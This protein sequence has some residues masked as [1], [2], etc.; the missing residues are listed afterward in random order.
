M[1]SRIHTPL[2]STY[3]KYQTTM[4]D[5]DKCEG[6]DENLPVTH[7]SEYV[8]SQC[9]PR[10]H[11][12][13]QN[14]S[15]YPAIDPQPLYAAQTYRGKVVIVTGASRGIGQEISLQYARAGATLAI[16]ARSE[17]SLGETKS[18]ILAAVP[19]AEVLVLST[20]V[21]DVKGTEKVVQA[22]LARFGKL[23]ILIAN[24]GA[25]APIDQS[26]RRLVPR[27]AARASWHC[28][29]LKFNARYRPAPEGSRFV[30]ELV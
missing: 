8:S 23:D 19:S 24:A 20:D 26:R 22:V 14:R 18:A 25:I 7:H 3:C 10:R 9:R 2:F 15:V 5:W 11:F 1:I 17:E 29:V 4:P 27:S 6:N 21:R 28:S 16:V 12:Y 30:V 13:F